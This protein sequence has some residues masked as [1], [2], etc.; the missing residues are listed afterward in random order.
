MDAYEALSR[1][2]TILLNVTP[3]KADCGRA[4]GGAC[5]A[6]DEDGQ[7]GMLLFPAEARFYTPLPE[8]F[9]ITPDKSVVQDGLLLT[10]SGTCARENRPLACRLFPLLP[11]ER[12]GG[13]R[14]VRDGRAWAVCPLM[15][16]GVRGLDEAFVAA[17]REAGALLYAC[18][19]HRR[20]LNALHA[21][22][23]RVMTRSL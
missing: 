6:P 5:C 3:L 1:A 14:V 4:C 15:D 2:R 13:M 22:I 17:V 21:A 11:L 20:F 19:E 10:C 18:P 23:A 12:D 16:S 8:G 9:L 7:G